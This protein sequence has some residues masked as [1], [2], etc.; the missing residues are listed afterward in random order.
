MLWSCYQA[1]VGCWDIAPSEFWEMSHEEFWKLF[2][3]RRRDAAP[4]S[5]LTADD[6]AEL[7]GLLETANG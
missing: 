1:A 4:G 6:L 2:D 7:Y 5:T 3:V